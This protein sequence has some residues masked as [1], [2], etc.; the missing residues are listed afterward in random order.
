MKK[1]IILCTAFYCLQAKAQDAAKDSLLGWGGTFQ[2]DG[3]FI[4]DSGT[5]IKINANRSLSFSYPGNSG[6]QTGKTAVTL[7]GYN[8][9]GDPFKKIAEE[10]QKENE[11]ENKIQTAFAA[12]RTTGASY[13]YAVKQAT[14]E[15]KDVANDIKAD[16]SFDPQS[17]DS[18]E[19]SE[20]GEDEILQQL[21]NKVCNEGR[22]DHDEL[23]RRSKIR[24]QQR[25]NKQFGEPAPPVRDIDSYCYACDTSLANQYKRA[26]DE[27]VKKFTAEDTFVIIQGLSLSKTI[28]LIGG[29]SPKVSGYSGKTYYTMDAKF[30]ELIAGSKAHPNS[31]AW[32]S[33]APDEIWDAVIKIAKYYKAK[34]INL[35]EK[36]HAVPG[37]E[38]AL[39]RVL[40]SV[41]RQCLLLGLPDT[42]E[43][44]DKVTAIILHAKK[45]YEDRLLVN[46]E[47]M[48]L[49]NFAY[50]FG[51]L[52][53]YALMGGEV[54][55]DEVINKFNEA[56]HFTLSVDMNIKMG[57]DRGYAIAHVKGSTA[58]VA[59]PDSS[60][61]LKFSLAKEE[62]NLLKLD[63]I[64]NKVIGPGPVP[65]YADVMKA[66][67]P[68][69]VFSFHFCTNEGPDT[70]YVS[71]FVPA[72]GAQG[73]WTLPNGQRAPLFLNG[74]DGSFTNHRQLAE[75]AKDAAAEAGT[76]QQQ[77]V[78]MQSDAEEIQR[79][80]AALQKAGKSPMEIAGEIKKLQGMNEGVRQMGFQKLADLKIPVKLQAGEEI[81]FKEKLDA[82]K[83]NPEESNLIVYGDLI[84]QL[85]YD[86]K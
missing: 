18:K 65:V 51:I 64:E 79:K 3:S 49:A 84:I 33:T 67:S 78:K 60:K 7:K 17:S 37:A 75:D 50:Y 1:I 85:R 9:N 42:D 61:C 44:M 38:Y 54:N 43:V 32:L 24:D 62:K 8:N 71:H 57:K 34:V 68:L 40:L 58:V 14:D 21:V 25:I 11:F 59:T 6:K 66:E 52:R 76:D 74:L 36:Y 22:H 81:L 46:K 31:C 70:I 27:Y 13:F 55:A 77:L 73:L 15:M 28:Q 20:P 86:P 23:I 12:N 63:I 19:I 16:I 48:Q 5:I 4:T 41:E 69:P 47:Y 35:Y 29:F 45:D 10:L 83:I 26:V 82:K 30:A 53:Q 39:I 80:L 56:N 72:N 2:K